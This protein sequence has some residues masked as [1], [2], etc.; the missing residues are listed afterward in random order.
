MN[1]IYIFS[2]VLQSVNTQPGD[3]TGIPPGAS[4]YAPDIWSALVSEYGNE[5]ELI[6]VL[7]LKDMRNVDDQV[8]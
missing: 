3:I 4:L 7:G 1:N 5:R 8:V 6:A 2:G